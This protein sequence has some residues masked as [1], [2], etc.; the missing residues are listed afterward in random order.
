M[1]T[2]QH[3]PRLD[4]VP[5]GW[6]PTI[7]I[8]SREQDPLPFTYPTSTTGLPTGDYSAVGL[9]HDLCVE[10]KSIGDLVGS[11]TA[12]RDR[13][14]REIQRMRSYQ[15]RRLVIIGCEADILEG[16]WRSKVKPLAVVHSLHSIESKGIPVVYASNPTTAASLIEQWAFWR[17][18]EVL[19]HAGR[20]IQATG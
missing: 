12:E 2:G 7:L 20:I 4:L 17:L 19:R 14:M 18:R 9:E 6:T 11:L 10:R 3:L 15:F 16:R 8:D 1:T 13:F 5:E